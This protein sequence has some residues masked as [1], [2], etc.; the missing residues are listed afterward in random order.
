MM[1]FG[2]R[3]RLGRGKRGISIFTRHSSDEQLLVL[4]RLID[5]AAAPSE[6]EGTEAASESFCHRRHF[7]DWTDDG[8]LDDFGGLVDAG[9]NVLADAI[10]P[11][12]LH[13][14]GFA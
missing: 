3:T 7:S 8:I 13:V 5:R 1:M 4:S 14:Q 11:F 9:H 10:E 12:D 6:K 2:N